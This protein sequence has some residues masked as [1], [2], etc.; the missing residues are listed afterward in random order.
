[1]PLERLTVR[2]VTLLWQVFVAELMSDVEE[3]VAQS[4]HGR[5]HEDIGRV[6][7]REFD[8]KLFM[9]TLRVF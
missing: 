8:G 5:S 6:L 4:S 3:C 1:M 2:E 9:F 7:S